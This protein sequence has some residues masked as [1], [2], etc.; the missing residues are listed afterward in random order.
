MGE[1]TDADREAAKQ[2]RVIL[3]DVCGFWHNSGDEGAL[4]LAFASHRIETE[5]RMLE[6]AVRFGR[7]TLHLGV[8]RN[9]Q[10]LRRSRTKTSPTFING[11]SINGA[12]INGASVTM[13][14]VQT[15]G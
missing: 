1:I 3:A 7:N 5:S 12:S 14:D 10:T 2:L 9:P 15:A 11:A 4:C 6:S 8:E 13:E